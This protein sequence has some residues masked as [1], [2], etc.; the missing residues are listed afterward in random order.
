[1]P[2]ISSQLQTGTDKG[3][4]PV[5]TTTSTHY[6]KDQKSRRR[7]RRG[8]GSLQILPPTEG[9]EAMQGLGPENVEG[10]ETLASTGGTEGP[11]LDTQFG[12]GD[13]RPLSI[14]TKTTTGTTAPEPE[15]APYQYNRGNLGILQ[16][17][18]QRD[19][20]G[21]MGELGDLTPDK[22]KMLKQLLILLK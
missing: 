22:L 19:D 2:N 6:K 8:R 10:Y 9:E 4:N 15:D 1:M 7:R 18:R 5:Y 12:V 14:N 17:G 3:G 16:R 13:Q 11:E 20:G 21:Y